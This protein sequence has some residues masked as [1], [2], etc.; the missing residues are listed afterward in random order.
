M[1]VYNVPLSIKDYLK[2]NVRY[3]KALEIKHKTYGYWFVKGV[4]SKNKPILSFLYAFIKHPISGVAWL[5]LYSYGKIMAI[6][7]TQKEGVWEI[8]NTTK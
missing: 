1:V 4:I 5:P 6:G 7:N 2:Q 3:R 8:S